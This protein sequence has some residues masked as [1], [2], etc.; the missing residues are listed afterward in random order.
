MNTGK[1]RDII[2]D[3]REHPVAAL[4]QGYTKSA[5]EGTLERAGLLLT[6]RRLYYIGTTYGTVGSAW[7]GKTVTNEGAIDLRYVSAVNITRTDTKFPLVLSVAL[8]CMAPFVFLGDSQYSMAAGWFTTWAAAV[9]LLM[10]FAGIRK[11]FSVDFI[12]GA[13]VTVPA[14]WY[15]MDK[16]RAFRSAIFEAKDSITDSDRYHDSFHYTDYPPSPRRPQPSLLKRITRRLPR[17]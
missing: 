3:P 14:R 4:G 11:S 10:Y 7:K 13:P 15:S 5:L 12:G 9:S 1:W 2:Q 16:L 17:K 8:A 6:D